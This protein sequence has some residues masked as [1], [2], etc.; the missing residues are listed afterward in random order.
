MIKEK[1]VLSQK[2]TEQKENEK[3]IVSPKKESQQVN[4]L[5]NITSPILLSK[6][7][8][9]TK[10]KMTCE[11]IGIKNLTLNSP[12][13]QCEMIGNIQLLS[14]SESP[15]NKQENGNLRG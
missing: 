15:E 2:D 12:V 4:P 5:K 10:D 9:G 11:E 1:L 6:A 7:R 13:P 3:S 14:K 8:N